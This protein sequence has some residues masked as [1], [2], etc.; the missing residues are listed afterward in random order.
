MI[1]RPTVCLSVCLSADKRPLAYRLYVRLRIKDA[2]KCLLGCGGLG[3]VATG[4]NTV[5]SRKYYLQVYKLNGYIELWTTFTYMVPN[6]T[7]MVSEVL[8]YVARKRLTGAPK[9]GA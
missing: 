7:V 6:C 2:S 1:P 5:R 4:N 9:K 8:A 3:A